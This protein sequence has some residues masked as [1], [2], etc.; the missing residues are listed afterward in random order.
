MSSVARVNVPVDAS[1]PS[2]QASTV[3]YDGKAGK[4]SAYLARPASQG[5]FP[6]ILVVHENRG[7]NDHIRDVA[8]RVAKHGYV[9]VAP[10]LL[11]RLGG[12]DKASQSGEI[13]EVIR[14]IPRQ[15][16]MEDM[17]ST[18]EFARSLSYV[19]AERIGCTGFCFG[20]G[21]TWQFATLTRDLHAAVPYYG[22]N[23]PLEDVHKITA[24][25][26]AMYGGT[27]E[28]I[29][30]GIPAI[31]KAMSENRKDFAYKV[32]PGAAH[33]F[34]NDKG[35][36]YHAGAAEEAWQLALQFFDKH[37]KK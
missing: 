36:N 16:F 25:I 12:T 2:I 37:L 24:P 26:H 23:P 5:R 28:R 9:A 1:D 31:E 8:R 35:A 21:I 33:A 27:D 13:P 32:F 14:T 19:N 3:Q 22:S 4:L 11:S 30:A 10:D 6:A 34:N 7:L 20:G 18:L 15:N 17:L 29:N